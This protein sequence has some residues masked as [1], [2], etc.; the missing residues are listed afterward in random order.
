M[1]TDVADPQSLDALIRY[2]HEGSKEEGNLRIGGEYELFGVNP[3]TCA[4]VPYSGKR[5]IETIL[6]RMLEN[7]RWSPFCEG[8]ELISLL[9]KDGS[10]ITLEPGAQVELS[11][12]PQKRLENLAEELR[13]FVGELYSVS[14]DLG[15]EFIGMGMHPVSLEAE[16]PFIN[17]CRYEVMAPYLKDKGAH[18]N[19]MMK[20]TAT[21][22]VNLDYTDEADAMDKMCTIMGI[23]S[24]VSAM[25]ANSPLT[26]GKPNGFMTRR[27]HVW[28]DTDPDRCGL[29]EFVFNEDASFR[30]YLDYALNVPMMLA[31]RNGCCIPM[32]GVP[33]GRF[34]Q[35]GAHGVD[36][37]MDD[38]HLHLSTLFPEVRL[39]QYIEIRGVD[40]QAP[41]MALAVPSF[42]TGII[43]DREARKAAWDMVKAWSFTE[44]L[45]LHEDICRLGLKADIRGTAVLDLARELVRIAGEGLRRQGETLNFMTPLEELVLKQGRSPADVL[46]EKWNAWKGDVTR[47]IRYASYFQ[48]D[49]FNLDI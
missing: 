22:Q 43:Y 42:W 48:S 10:N 23:T 15:I 11:G 24:I 17:K 30:D 19:T 33:F 47:L 7:P 35:E 3:D 39:K 16:I 40:G 2:F 41:H 14:R 20:E 44:R 18:S 8:Q 49:M 12:A 31:I 21:V 37:I 4:A 36:P 29:L 1:T 6:K 27:E 45:Q 25:F 5:G 13:Q 32:Q 28:L 26:G 46:L 9:G 38:W 34:L